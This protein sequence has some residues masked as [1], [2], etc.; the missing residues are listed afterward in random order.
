NSICN[1]RDSNVK[2]NPLE[3]V[4]KSGNPLWKICF[5]RRHDRS[6]RLAVMRNGEVVEPLEAHDLVI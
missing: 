6:D 5:S 1:S 4:P 2:S 3:H